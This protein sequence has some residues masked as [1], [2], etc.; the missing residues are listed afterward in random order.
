MELDNDPMQPDR[1]PVSRQLSHDVV[2]A[3]VECNSGQASAVLRATSIISISS[4]N[5]IE[6]VHL[7]RPVPL[8]TIQEESPWRRSRTCNAANVIDLSKKDDDSMVQGAYNANLANAP[9]VGF[10][11]KRE[12][13]QA[14]LLDPSP[15]RWPPPRREQWRQII[16]ISDEDG[17]DDDV[18]EEVDG[19]AWMRASLRQRP[20]LRRKKLTS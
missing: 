16:N 14:K 17:D 9:N 12:D 4:D 19:Y 15:M 18:M 5:E 3:A 13:D 10:A 1:A 11:H 6:P 20:G 7:N 2:L 8:L